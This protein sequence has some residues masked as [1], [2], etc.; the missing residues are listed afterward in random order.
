MGRSVSFNLLPAEIVQIDD[1]L[2]DPG[3]L[4]AR[5][6][7]LRRG[8]H[9]DAAAARPQAAPITCRRLAPRAPTTRLTG[10]LE[11]ADQRPP[12]LAQRRRHLRR[13]RAGLLRAPQRRAA[14]ARRRW[15]TPRSPARCRSARPIPA[16]RRPG[17]DPDRLDAVRT[18][19]DPRGRPDRRAMAAERQSGASIWTVSTPTSTPATSTTTTCIGARNELNNNLPTSFTVANNTLTS[20][21]LADTATPA[22]GVAGGVAPAARST[23]SSSTTSSG[24]A[25]AP[26]P[27]YINLDGKYQSDRPPDHQAARSA[28]RRAR[29]RPT[30]RL[31]SRSTAPT[32]VSYAL[33]QRLGRSTPTN[34]NPSEPGR[35]LQRLGVE[36]AVPLAGQGDL[37]PGRRQVR[38]RRGW[39]VQ[40]RR[41]RLPRLATHPPGRRLGPRLHARRQRPMLDQRRPM[42]FSATNPQPYPSGFNAGALG[43]PGLLIPIAGNPSTI[44]NILNSITDGVHGPLSSIVTAAELLLEP[45]RSRCRRTTTRATSWPTSAAT[46]G[47]ATSACAW[48]TPTRTSFVNTASA[49]PTHPRPPA[50]L[51]ARSAR[52]AYGGYIANDVKH[53]YFDVAAE[54][55][56]HL[57]PAEEPAAAR[58]R[59]PRP[60]RGRTTAPWARPSA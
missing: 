26:T 3:R 42:P 10:R 36:R 1:G 19:D 6:R 22:T 37:R 56:L 32:G 17:A 43:I 7:R 50:R 45:A 9:P 48:S 5:R 23:A 38:H 53:N 2:Q 51:P 40:G 29:A 41:V 54:R 49:C 15:A 33:R 16:G 59:R 46:T 24:P 52:S 21:V 18:G 47:A 35:P 60:C 57:R 4:A 20:A 27:A 28:T 12:R 34:I 30:A 31:R 14:T 25:P 44:V 13:H 11:A 39:R 58:S 55:E 8:R